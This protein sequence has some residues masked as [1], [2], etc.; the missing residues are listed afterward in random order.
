MRVNKSSTLPALLK[1]RKDEITGR[2]VESDVVHS[3]RLGLYS[4]LFTLI[5]ESMLLPVQ[6]QLHNVYSLSL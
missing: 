1:L 5:Y 6:I 2:E 3:I 4:T